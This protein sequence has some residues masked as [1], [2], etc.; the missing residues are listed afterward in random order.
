[1]DHLLEKLKL[2]RTLKI[3]ITCIFGATKC[4]LKLELKKTMQQKKCHLGREV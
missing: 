1:M 3:E 4:Q 2:M